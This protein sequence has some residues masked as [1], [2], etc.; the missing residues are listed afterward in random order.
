VSTAPAQRL[1]ARIA[2]ILV[3]SG[4]VSFRT[5]PFFRF[6]SG[7][8]SPVYVDN[9][10]LL[11]D[12]E[13]RLEIIAALIETAT[14]KSAAVVAG[15]ATAGIPWGA[16]LADRMALP[17]LYVRSEAKTWGKERTVEGAAPEGARVLVIEDL[18]YSAGSLA[19]AAQNLREAGFLV[20]DALTIASYDMPIA[21]SR[22]KSLAL[23]HTS[24][25]TIDQAL[26][27]AQRTGSLDDREV[28][29]VEEWLRDRRAKKD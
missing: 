9:R 7:A 24:L 29:V 23:T 28:S 19:A 13:A 12:V 1:D 11:G 27:A 25:T 6:T 5:S 3:S 26:A 15:T 14:S 10:Q 22:L 8:E 16:W 21:H 20:N 18:A 17:F 2:E 4:A